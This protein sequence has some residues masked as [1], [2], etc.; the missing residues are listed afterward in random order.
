MLGGYQ[1]MDETHELLLAHACTGAVLDTSSE[2]FAQ[3][4]G[5]L[6]QL[7]AATQEYQFG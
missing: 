4:V 1:L 3:F 5:Q 7:I 6:L 2:E